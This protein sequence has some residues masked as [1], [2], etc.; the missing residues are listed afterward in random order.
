MSKVDISCRNLQVNKTCK[1]DDYVVRKLDT[2]R[3]VCNNKHAW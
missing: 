1:G 3:Y 2:V